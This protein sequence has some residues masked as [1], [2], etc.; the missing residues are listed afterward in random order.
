MQT[1][2]VLDADEMLRVGLALISLG[3]RI[4]PILKGQ[5]HPGIVGWQNLIATPALVK[6]WVDSGRYG[7]W[8]VMGLGGIDAD[9]YNEGAAISFNSCVPKALPP[10][11]GRRPKVLYVCTNP[12]N[13]TKRVSDGYVDTDGN[14]NKVEFLGVGQQF[15]TWGD[16]PETG[17]PYK[18]SSNKPLHETPIAELQPIT[19]AQV[20]AMIDFFETT[21][22]PPLVAAGTWTLQAKGVSGE[23]SNVIETSAFENIVKA[24][25]PGNFTQTQVVAAL[26][27]LDPDCNLQEWVEVGMALYH[28]YQGGTEGLDIFEQWSASKQSMKYQPGVC[29]RRWPSFKPDAGRNSITF[30]SIWQRA[31]NASR[32]DKLVVEERESDDLFATPVARTLKARTLGASFDIHSLQPRPWVF[33]R[34]FLKGYIS[35]T[36]GK[37]GVSKS[38][39]SILSCLSVALGR[40]L[41]GETVHQEGS[42]LIINNEDKVDEIERRLAAACLHYEIP[43]A[44]VAD[45]LHYFSGYDAET[46]TLCTRDDLGN[47]IVTPNVPALLS[48]IK[49][50]NIIMCS[51]DPFIS[52]HTANENDNG[53][54]ERVMDTFRHIAAEGSCAIELIH[55][56]RK[57][58]EAGDAEAARGAS[59]AIAAARVVT[60]LSKMTRAEAKALHIDFDAL[61][62]MLV[63]SDIGKENF[64]LGA[65]GA[66]WYLMRSVTLPN[67][68]EVGVHE[69]YD[70][71][72]HEAEADEEDAVATEAMN[73]RYRIDVLCALGDNTDMRITAAMER[74]RGVWGLNS[75]NALR[76]RM[77]CALHF[78]RSNANIIEHGGRLVHLWLEQGKG[79]NSPITVRADYA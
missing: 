7:G 37:A 43:F 63:R 56:V 18:Y 41:T 10:R 11:V 75:D 8:G 54:I 45:K 49:E 31:K 72:V 48:Y 73:A 12:E 64:S 35:A 21:V 6:E 33:G 17:K 71:T 34:R 23:T 61:G 60:T 66:T 1:N 70:V 57:G 47:V 16:H 39:F 67:G 15:V 68:D 51:L 58:G 27:A 25:Q 20:A 24:E 2:P 69:L 36:I 30:A 74:L 4:V 46:F 40:G 3:Y 52:T 44:Q 62:Y 29:E 55:H 22:V 78:D 42:V 19:A 79:A 5:K 9:I 32:H 76:K 59:S 77:T 65:A 53:E 26:K 38:T 50:H 28:Q 13:L 14:V